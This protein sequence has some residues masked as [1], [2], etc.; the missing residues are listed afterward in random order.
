M[1]VRKGG[2]SVKKKLWQWIQGMLCMILIAAAAMGCAVFRAA[3]EVQRVWEVTQQA[4]QDIKE[5]TDPV[6]GAPAVT[7]L[8]SALEPDGAQRILL[9]GDRVPDHAI[10]AAVKERLP[11]YASCTAEASAKA[12]KAPLQAQTPEWTLQL[13]D[14]WDAH[15]CVT[16]GNGAPV[17]D[18]AV[19]G[20][21]TRVFT[22]NGTDTCTLTLKQETADGIRTLTYGFQVVLDVQPTVEL[23]KTVLAQG[24]VAAVL[25]SGNIFGE[26]MTITT[27]LGLCDFV[28]LDTPGC[29]GAYVPV[30]YNRGVGEWPIAVTVGDTIHEL[31]VTVEKRDFT[32]QHMTIS[33]TVADNTWNSAAASSEYRAAIYPLYEVTD[34]ERR[35]DGA[36]IEPVTGYRL[37]TQ[38]GLWRYT[39]GVYSERHSGIDMACP[40]GTPIVAPQNGVVL[41]AQYLQLTGNT[42]VIAHGGGVK[43]IFYH[44]DS[45]DVAAGD[46]VTTGQKIAEVG[47]T[48]YSTGPHLHYEVKIGSQSIDPF[49]LFD[50]SSGLFAGLS[51]MK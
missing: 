22:A 38:Y 4:L 47:T 44:M 16:D 23:A 42:I 14:G 11:Q 12:Q 10:Y 1:A 13:P 2:S 37:T 30:A 41:F 29:Y 45:I 48:G 46:I 27:E 50:G 9:L 15:L 34:T 20:A 25:V 36:F 49:Q 17:Y 6:F 39:N 26:P 21:Y 40:L 5:P 3:A 33:K 24:D 31:A 28:A 8:G 19:K 35:W 18:D 43:S 7:V 51:A 32:V